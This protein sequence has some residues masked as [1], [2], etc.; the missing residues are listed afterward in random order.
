[1]QD[2]LFYIQ[3]EETSMSNSLKLRRCI[4]TCLCAYSVAQSCPALCDLMDCSPPG[5]SVHGI[6]LATILKKFAISSSRGSSP[7]LPQLL[8]WQMHSLLLAW[9]PYKSHTW[10]QIWTVI[11]WLW[12]G[13]P[14]FGASVFSTVVGRLISPRDV[15][16]LLRT[17]EYAPRWHGKRDFTNVIK[18][19]RP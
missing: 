17:S 19:K 8:H 9:G 10:I 2:G 1:M 3:T 18:V 7:H 4:N 16:P 11:Y 13:M 12:E 6:S 15:Q 14:I 5:S